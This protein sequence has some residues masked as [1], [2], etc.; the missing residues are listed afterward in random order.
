M[1]ESRYFP[2]N[3]L[4]SIRLQ[5]EIFLSEDNNREKIAAIEADNDMYYL[6]T[7][8]EKLPLDIIPVA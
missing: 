8:I 7:R 4:H 5:R 6:Q 1:L 3:E 2:L